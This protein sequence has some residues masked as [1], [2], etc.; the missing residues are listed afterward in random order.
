MWEMFPQK[1]P[2]IDG[3]LVIRSRELFDRYL[4]IVD[5][6]Q[7][8]YPLQKQYDITH[9]VLPISMNQRYLK[10][11]SML[12]LDKN[13]SLVFIDASSMVLVNQPHMTCQHIDLGSSEEIHKIRQGFSAQYN[14]SEALGFWA[15]TNFNNLLKMINEDKVSEENKNP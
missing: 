8:F 1:L 11:A 15:N 9:V 13:W 6:P 10:L 14:Q 7:S 3:R 12:Y 5:N 4:N 2:F